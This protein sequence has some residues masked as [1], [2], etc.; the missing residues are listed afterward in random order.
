MSGMEVI[1]VVLGVLP[2]VISAMEYYEETAKLSRAWWKIKRT[3]RRDTGLLKDCQLRLRLHLQELLH[4][5]LLNGII[6]R[7]EFDSLLTEVKS[8]T[9]AKSQTWDS[10][11]VNEALRERLPD[12]EIC[13]RYLAIVVEMR[14]TVKKLAK[15]TMIDDEGFQ[16]FLQ[17]QS[18]VPSL[19]LFLASKA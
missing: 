6:S 15:T 1:G 3:H 12:S 7:T 18:K 11:S 8:H 17:K 14:E 9:E 2:L 10:D 5:L 13:D 16:T 4:P 19:L